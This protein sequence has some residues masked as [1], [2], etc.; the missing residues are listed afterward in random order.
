MEEK[1]SIKA[2]KGTTTVGVICRNGVV[3]AADKRASSGYMVADKKTEKVHPISDYM[4]ITTSGLVSDAQLLTKVIKA[5]LKLLALR[6]GQE[7]LV[8]EA[9]NLLSN[10]S[11]SNIRKPSMVP[12]I[13]GFLLAGY[14]KHGFHLYDIGVDGSISKAEDFR[15]DGSGSVYAMGVLE[16]LYKKDMNLEEGTDLVV[17]A[18]KAALRRDLATGNGIDVFHITKDGV[19][20]VLTKIFD[21]QV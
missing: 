2:K 3:L 11:Y 13:V 6:K 14:D 17:K 20:K 21:I 15:T 16:T 18:L 4:A 19:K 10:L 5:Q 8:A 9:A 12:G 7:P 1:D